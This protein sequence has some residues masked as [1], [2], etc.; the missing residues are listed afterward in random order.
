MPISDSTSHF[1]IEDVLAVHHLITIMKVSRQCHSRTGQKVNFCKFQLISSIIIIYLIFLFIK[2]FLKARCMYKTASCAEIAGNYLYHWINVTC[3]KVAKNG[4]DLKKLA[5][6]N[7]KLANVVA[8]E[9]KIL[10]RTLLYVS[11]IFSL[12]NNS[13]SE[14]EFWQCA[15][16]PF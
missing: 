6:K 5:Q 3:E 16:K 13:I 15:I 8:K 11:Y 9:K 7:I 14:Y 10:A 12:F 4:P 2:Y 1:T